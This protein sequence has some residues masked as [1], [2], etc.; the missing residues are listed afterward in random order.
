VRQASGPLPADGG[1]VVTYTVH[2]APAPTTTIPTPTTTPTTTVPVAKPV[3]QPVVSHDPLP[4][5]GA[6]VVLEITASFGLLVAGALAALL[7]HRR[8][9]AIQTAPRPAR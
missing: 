5:T 7:A 4:L 9:P 6:P 2:G 1:V 3:P 8:A